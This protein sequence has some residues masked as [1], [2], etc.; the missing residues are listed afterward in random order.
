MYLWD[1]H[2]V[3][4][5]ADQHPTL[6]LHIQRVE[7]DEVGLP[8]PAVAE[9]LRGRAVFA[10][11]ATPEQVIWAHDHLWQSYVLITKF[12]VLL[13]D[14]EARDELKKLLKK[15]KAKKRYADMMI[16]AMA[17]AGNHTV[18]TRNTKHFADLLPPP[19]LA[20]WIDEPPQ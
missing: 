16:A 10:L 6:K 1:T 19:Q 2:M 9:V 18:V 17:L 15:F 14:E 13:F 8:T 5:Y 11:K 20:N 4:H 7:W 3:G 12:K